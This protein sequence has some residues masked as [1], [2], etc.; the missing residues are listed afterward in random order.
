[1]TQDDRYNSL[2]YGERSKWD[3]YYAEALNGRG[4]EHE[5]TYWWHL[6]EIE[7]IE[8]VASLFQGRSDLKLIEAGCGSGETSFH[9]A[10]RVPFSQISLVDVSA[11]A[12]RFAN[13]LQPGPSTYST[14]YV[15]ADVQRLPFRPNSF[16]LTWNVG[17]IEHY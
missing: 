14:E 16:D 3:E 4:Q 15:V 13:S 17:L 5:R 11:N 10:E 8:T 6:S 7:T 2:S 1:M 9:L 12:L